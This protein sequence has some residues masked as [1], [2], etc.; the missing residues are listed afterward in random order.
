VAQQL[1]L[2]EGLDRRPS[3]NDFLW[4]YSIFWSRAISMPL[5]PTTVIEGLVPGLDFA[6]HDDSSLCRWTMGTSKTTKPASKN[7]QTTQ[8]LPS[9]AKYA[10]VRLVCPRGCRIHPGSEVTINYGDKSNEELLYL[11]GFA[12]E[13]NQHDVLMVAC[14]LPP[15]SEWDPTLQARIEL[16]RSRGLAPQVFLPAQ[17][18][19]EASGLRRSRGRKRGRRAGDGVIGDSDDAVAVLDLPP[20]VMET[21]EVFVMEKKDVA[22]ELEGAGEGATAGRPA[23]VAGLTEMEGSGLRLALLTTLVRLLELKVSELDGGED[24]TGPP[25]GDERLLGE[26]VLSKRQRAAVVYRLGQKRL[27]RQYLLYTNALLQQEMRHLR[28][29]SEM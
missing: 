25:E 11:Y 26:A 21:L 9:T 19:V 12:K 28:G 13:G 2:A 27:A 10:E 16:L 23:S 6:N 8:N 14:P 15:P 4:A 24:G 22:A 20:G 18:L 1:A 29:L 7:T 5:G 3:L 17:H